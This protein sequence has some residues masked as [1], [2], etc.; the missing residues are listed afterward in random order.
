VVKT[1]RRRRIVAVKHRVV[2]GTQ[3]AVERVLAAYGWQINTAFVERAQ[4][5][6]AAAGG[7]DEAAQRHAV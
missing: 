6:P 4:S 2:F 5:E 3:A 1:M 7:G